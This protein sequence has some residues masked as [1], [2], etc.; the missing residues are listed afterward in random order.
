MIAHSVDKREIQLKERM[1]CIKGI[2]LP[3][4]FISDQLRP[5]RSLTITS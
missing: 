1:V 4:D 2:Q 5:T 3:A